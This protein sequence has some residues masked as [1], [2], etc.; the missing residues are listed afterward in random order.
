MCAC[1][2]QCSMSLASLPCSPCP[3]LDSSSDGEPAGSD[4]D[5]DVAGEEEE[6]LLQRMLMVRAASRIGCLCMA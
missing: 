5:D 1:S 3:A 6:D 4:S 2:L